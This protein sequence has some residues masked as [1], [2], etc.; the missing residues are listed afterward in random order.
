MAHTTPTSHSTAF[1]GGATRGG[2]GGGGK[3]SLVLLVL[4]CACFLFAVHMLTRPSGGGGAL[5]LSLFGASG[6]SA[7][8]RSGGGPIPAERGGARGPSADGDDV[9]PDT[10]HAGAKNDLPIPQKQ[11]GAQQ[12]HSGHIIVSRV[13]SSNF[14][15]SAGGL[16]PP[17][18]R[19]E[20]AIREMGG[21]GLAERVR[22]GALQRVAARRHSVDPSVTVEGLR[23]AERGRFEGRAGGAHDRRD[24]GAALYMYMYSSPDLPQCPAAFRLVA[25]EVNDSHVPDRNADWV[26][27]KYELY[28]SRCERRG[29]IMWADLSAASYAKI[30]I[31]VL[32]LLLLGGAD[33]DG[34]VVPEADYYRPLSL[35]LPAADGVASSHRRPMVY[36]YT[37]AARS[38]NKNDDSA[39][40]D[41][42]NKYSVYEDRPYFY[43]NE[44]RAIVDGL[45]ASGQFYMHHNHQN[46]GG[47][48]AMPSVQQKGGTM[49]EKE[50]DAKGVLSLRILDWG[51]GCGIGVSFFSNFIAEAMGNYSAVAASGGMKATATRGQG[52]GNSGGKTLNEENEGAAAAAAAV[53][54]QEVSSAALPQLRLQLLSLD[55]IS[56]A[57]D[58]AK[59]RYQPEA[60]SLFTSAELFGA[61]SSPLQ[62]SPRRL[63]HPSSAVRFCHADGTDL[64][65]IPPSSFDYAV[66]FG[67][68]LHV[69][70]GRLCA[71]VAQ[72]LRSVRV[73]GA[74]WGGYIDD[75][76]TVERL[77]ACTF[78]PTTSSSSSSPSS[79]TEEGTQLIDAGAGM[80][81]QPFEV[82]LTVLRERDWYRHLGM[83]KALLRRRPHSLLW[84]K[85]S[86]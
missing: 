32:K 14:G 79:S 39:G 35:P 5:E 19:A 30:G 63:F 7:L 59:R 86:L 34:S 44:Q 8:A 4:L 29:G 12:G 61:T 73:G 23:D 17:R 55:L 82:R 52:D 16:P 11:G 83:P 13:A 24:E 58:F 65:F 3:A 68:L 51:G 76:D 36:T 78:S 62:S 50:A 43:P 25:K 42:H 60:E 15:S 38:N 53:H 84:R 41:N 22:A 49:E 10:V 54:E 48:A 37:T 2:G 64:S 1:A 20:D 6:G 46:G 9:H 72:L 57:I 69:P 45:L 33:T 67:A 26:A 81:H 40:N 28:A 31:K 21:R 71:T 80:S 75:W 47:D 85:V 27:A 70:A 74:V 77:S 66:A 56:G 18:A